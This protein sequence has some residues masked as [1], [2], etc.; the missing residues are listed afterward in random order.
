[1]STNW[2]E[3]DSKSKKEDGCFGIVLFLIVSAATLVGSMV[4][5]LV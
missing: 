5:V 4:Y 1:M 3:P 2:I